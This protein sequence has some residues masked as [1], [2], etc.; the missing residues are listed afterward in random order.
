MVR[1]SIGTSC[2]SWTGCHQSGET[3]R[4]R[5]GVGVP[6]WEKGIVHD[7]GKLFVLRG[8]CIPEDKVTVSGRHD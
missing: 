1:S 7:A 6:Y 5:F 3:E 2:G 8:V 4:V